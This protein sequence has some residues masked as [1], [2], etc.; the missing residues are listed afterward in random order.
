MSQ[1]LLLLLLSTTD[2]VLTDKIYVRFDR[3]ALRVSTAAGI[4][5]RHNLVIDHA[6]LPFEY[7][8][9]AV[10]RK[11]VEQL[12]DSRTKLALELEEPL[13]RT[14]VVQCPSTHRNVS[15][16]CNQLLRGCTGIEVAEPISI[17]QLCGFTPTD[18]LLSEQGMLATIS[19]YE[20]WEIEK[21]SDTVRIGISDSGVR[22][23]HEDLADNIAVNAGEIPDN[24]V[25]DDNNGYI[26]DHRGYSFTSKDD[27]TKPGDTFN[28][29]EGHGTAVAGICSASTNNAKGIAGVGFNCKIVPLKT[30]P[31]GQRG[32][33]YGYESL[34]YC[35][36]NGVSVV[37]C[38]WGGF[39]RS[40]T[41]EAVVRYVL[42]RGTA[43]VAAAGNH[44][45][46]APFYPAGYPGV[47][48][49]GVTDPRD[50]V[51]AMS[52]MG[53]GVDVMAPGNETK[54][55]SNDGTYG[56]FC[57]T[58]GSSP[59]VAGVVG[60]IRSRHPKLTPAQALAL[61]RESV[62]DIRDKNPRY[63]DIMPGR[64]NALKAVTIDPDSIPGITVVSTSITNRRNAAR[65]GLGDTIDVVL[66]I[67]NELAAIGPIDAA[68]TVVRD[69]FASV[70]LLTSSLTGSAMNSGEEQ[71]LPP[72]TLVV[73]RSSDTSIIV[74]AEL[75]GTPVKGGSYRTSALASVTPAPAYLNLSNNVFRLSVGDRVRIGLTDPMRGQ[76]DGVSYRTECGMLAEGGVVAGSYGRVVSS[77]RSTRG[78]DDHFVPVKPFIDPDASY[79]SAVDAGAPDSMRLDLQIDQR[80][81]ISSNDSAVFVCDMTYTHIGDSTLSDVGIAWFLDWDL[82]SQPASNTTELLD[83]HAMPPS[84]IQVVSANPSLHVACAVSSPWSS[85]T[86]IACGLDNSTTYNGFPPAFKDSLLRSGTALQFTGAADISVLTGMMFHGAWRRGEVRTMRFVI[87]VDS[88]KLGASA[89][90]QQAAAPKVAT[91]LLIGSPFPLPAFSTINVP[92][93]TP[94]RDALELHVFD[95]QGHD[96]LQWSGTADGGWM[97][98][99]IDV[100]SLGS[101]AYTVMAV[102]QQQVVTAPLMVLR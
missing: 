79:G 82:G 20:A 6:L 21:G 7:S 53:P 37:N 26:D 88:T 68:I 35:A 42:A 91:T 13:L 1:L 51:V 65:Y 73:N 90:A 72:I 24:N 70:T 43:I 15:V 83:V 48:G 86:P 39:N 27:S 69:P 60:L 54:A 95:V 78:V 100:R 67:R 36:R 66:T 8:L 77:V 4:A 40:C 49:V 75:S 99:P 56:G 33:I 34:L 31:T 71:T 64:I 12:Q 84:A 11:E 97:N 89:L 41:D 19:A 9:T 102:F 55:T 52:A 38:S 85:A 5:A 22:Q 17:P 47:L 23:D 25:D 46:T 80:V 29:T 58:S 63:A 14:Y 44:G 16:L 59:I 93:A 18:S 87:A 45:T 30:M 101:G 28:P 76:G 32:I 50:T 3:D 61:A 96:L 2:P 10:Q 62:D 92:I 94:S 98:I 74:R 57:C 81:S